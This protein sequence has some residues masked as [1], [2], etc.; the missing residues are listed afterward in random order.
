MEKFSK[1]INRCQIS[2]KKDLKTIISLGFLPPVNKLRKINSLN[3]ESIFF[4]TDL[5]YS[6]SS[7]LVQLTNIVDKTILFPSEYPYTSSTTKILR[8]NFKELYNECSKLFDLYQDDL[9]VDIGSNDG[10]LLSNFK[11]N[12]KVLGITPEDIGKIAIK[13]GIKTLI[14][15]FD[16][17][18]SRYVL[19][20]FGKARIITATNVFAHIEDVGK[21]MKN[22][23]RILDNNGIFI[24]ESH[25][26]VSLLQ[27]LQ[28]D[29]IYH[30]HLR[31]YSLQSLKYLFDKYGLTIIHAKKIPTHGG[32]IRVYAAK[33]GKYKILDSAK[34]ILAY[35]KK[36]INWKNLNK[37]KDDVIKSKLN[38]YRILNGVRKKK[39]R[40]FGIGAPSRVSTLVNYLGLTNE[41][42]ENVCEIEGSYKIG[43]YMP[44]TNIPIVSETKLFKEKPEYAL[45]L[46]WHIS[47][48]LIFNLKKKGYKGKFI[49]PLP[50]PRIAQ[51]K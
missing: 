12:H 44:G 31:Y 3:Q 29:T 49:I 25:Y 10:N 20:K 5:K 4:P 27:T 40:I 6:K 18:T 11:N 9:V 45:L 51:G 32:S 26:L 43:N 19:N 30:E 16:E 33:K 35:E 46:S 22:V 21:L 2:G 1:T 8:E 50:V 36:Y 34:K 47:D 24:T 38:L 42:I 28:Y 41:I 39:K 7:K 15:Y 13:K 23:L 37:F 48:E 17:E 14:K